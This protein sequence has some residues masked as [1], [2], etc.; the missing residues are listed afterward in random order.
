MAL[1][2]QCGER[3]NNVSEESEEDDELCDGFK[4]LQRIDRD[5]LCSP[6]MIVRGIYKGEVIKLEVKRRTEGNFVHWALFDMS[7]QKQ[8]LCIKGQ[9]EY[10]YELS[11]KAQCTGEGTKVLGGW[12]WRGWGYGYINLFP[13]S[14]P[15]VRH[16]DIEEAVFYDGEVNQH[17]HVSGRMCKNVEKDETHAC[18]EEECGLRIHTVR[19]ITFETTEQ[20]VEYYQQRRMRKTR[21]VQDIYLS[22]VAF[23]SGEY[24]ICLHRDSRMNQG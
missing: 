15:R 7:K 24:Q 3:N 21:Q 6:R 4:F 8:L 9:M 12:R 2:G 10:R 14:D 5:F 11:N 17:F 20:P 18:N 1:P 16:V 19:F 22:L 23:Y 13:S